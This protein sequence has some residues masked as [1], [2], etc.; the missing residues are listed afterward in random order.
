MYIMSQQDYQEPAKKS[1]AKATT[2]PTDTLKTS[3]IKVQMSSRLFKDE[4][5]KSATESHGD[6]EILITVTPPAGTACTPTDVICVVDVSGSMQTEAT[7]KNAQG[8][9]EKHGLS[10]LDITKHAVKTVIETLGSNDRLGIVAYS[11]TARIVMQLRRM[12]A[13]GKQAAKLA[14]A[15]L[16]AGGST[17]LWDGLL[18]GMNLLKDR[19]H[20]QEW[21]KHRNAS[22]FLLTDGQPNIEPPRGHVPTLKRYLEKHPQVRFTI[23]TFGFGY[24]LDSDLLQDV[25]K[26]GQGCY[27][28]IPDSS[29][30]GTCFVNA[31]S[32]LTTIAAANMI[33][34]LE[35]EDDS[36]QLQCYGNHCTTAAS[37]GT[38]LQA[39]SLHFGQK[40]SFVVRALS[41][42]SENKA[43]ILNEMASGI[44][45]PDGKQKTSVPPLSCYV[46]F[47]DP[48]TGEVK[49]ISSSLASSSGAWNSVEVSAEKN[50]LI[51]VE[52]VSMLINF[53]E[54]RQEKKA[55]MM[56]TDIVKRI[57]LSDAYVAKHGATLALL[58]D[59]EG[60]V[61]EAVSRT[62]WFN[63]WGK[64]YLR[65][66][67]MAHQLQLCTN[68]KDPGLQLY[69][70]AL[71]HEQRDIA[72]DIFCNM[73]PPKP[74]R[75]TSSTVRVHSMAHYNCRG[76]G[77]FSGESKVHMANGDKKPISQLERGDKVLVSA[78]RR[79]SARVVCIVKTVCENG[80]AELVNFRGMR[81]TPWHPIKI[82]GTW[83]FPFYL[84]NCEPKIQRCDAI[85]SFILENRAPAAVI[86]GIEGISL[87]HNLR[88]AVVG[89]QYFG[90]DRV[91]NDVSQ[92]HGWDKGIVELDSKNCMVRSRVT[93]R[94]VKFHQTPPKD[95]PRKGN[96]GNANPARDVAVTY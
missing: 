87:G 69:G 82:N 65:S 67:V 92:M 32:N 3:P 50:R 22:V 64:H 35:S 94:I 39:G 11:S 77:C 88:G 79:Q 33:V 13:S 4:G 46:S 29:F 86:N 42:T 26:T 70:G 30:V 71:F 34:S 41:A 21:S 8:E 78:D 19:Q 95:R 31:L 24:N 55:K 47:S 90:S 85:Y 43:K 96:L 2:S 59:V 63:R 16:R 76:N 44:A 15:N 1:M 56:V 40:R 45:N 6:N 58:Q 91:I 27:Y 23:N 93:G 7:M 83:T 28:F 10:L 66:I 62:D 53:M 61:T 74:S 48:K 80:M 75:A 12:D 36:V 25:G 84:P 37:W 54:L 38:S 89:H 18:N 52:H 57:K 81:V 68:F 17:N 51:F 60:Q 20:S 5:N 14:V 72:D 9:T 49:R 73:P